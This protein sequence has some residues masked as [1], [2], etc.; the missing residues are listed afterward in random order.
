MLALLL[1]TPILDDFSEINSQE[2]FEHNEKIEKD[3]FDKYV[4]KYK[5]NN[6]IRPIKIE[7]VNFAR[8]NQDRS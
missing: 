7:K 2:N 4:E 5:K 8:Y 1:K 3:L 6:L